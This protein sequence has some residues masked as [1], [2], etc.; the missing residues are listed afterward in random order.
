MGIEN[1]PKFNPEQISPL[2]NQAEEGAEHKPNMV[3][4]VGTILKEAEDIEIKPEDRN[5]NGDL[6]V[7]PEGSIS[8]LGK[9]NELYW[10]I[11]RTKSFKDF[12]GDWQNTPELASKVISKKG[13]PLVVF[14]GVRPRRN[15]EVLD[16]YDKKI[17]DKD[18]QEDLHTHGAGIYFTPSRKLATRF[19]GYGGVIFPAFVKAR[20]PKYT[21]FMRDQIRE[22][23]EMIRVLLPEK[24]L[25][26]IPKMSLSLKNYDSI[27]GKSIEPS[28][29]Y[30]KDPEELYELAVKDVE[31]FLIIPSA[32]QNQT[33]QQPKT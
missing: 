10:R 22:A 13:E 30:T 2:G 15:D 12:F 14:R 28:K 1:G 21:N 17:Y 31:Q 3:E 32:I 27:F 23:R 7:S 16:P 19:A 29:S 20:N 6:L 24:L 11:V 4:L 5:E 25:K 8:D 18:F 33:E 26:I 9:Q